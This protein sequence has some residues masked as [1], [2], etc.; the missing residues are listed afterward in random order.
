MAAGEIHKDME[1]GFIKAEVYAKNYWDFIKWK[2]LTLI[3]QG[4][5][6]FL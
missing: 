5:L 6:H 4:N 3:L 1:R 2:D